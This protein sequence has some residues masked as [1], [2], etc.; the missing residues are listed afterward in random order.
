MSSYVENYCRNCSRC[1]VAKAGRKLHTKIDSLLADQPLD[2]LAVDFTVLEPACGVE[3][4]LVCT[5]IFSKF[6]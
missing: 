5:D 2:I 4:V 3:N 1:V 6:T